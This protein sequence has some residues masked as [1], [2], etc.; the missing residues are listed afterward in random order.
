MREEET[1]NKQASM[2]QRQVIQTVSVKKAFAG[3][4]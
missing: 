1:T 4:T 2:R 3:E